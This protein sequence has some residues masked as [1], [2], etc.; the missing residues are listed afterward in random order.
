MDPVVL[1]RNLETEILAFNRVSN[2]GVS[3][4]YIATPKSMREFVGEMQKG[5]TEFE[6]FTGDHLAPFLKSSHESCPDEVY[7]D[8]INDFE[9]LIEQEI[10]SK[11]VYFLGSASSS[12]STHIS[13]ERIVS[14]MGAHDI[15]NS[16]LFEN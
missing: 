4:I 14:G 5:M 11:S 16:V 9:S 13:Q 15:L 10:C 6:I 3:K 12:W 7:D 2:I 1:G 8:R